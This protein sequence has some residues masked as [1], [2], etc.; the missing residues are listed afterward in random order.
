MPKMQEKMD[1]GQQLGKSR[2]GLHQVSIERL[3]TQAGKRLNFCVTLEKV[4]SDPILMIL[5]CDFFTHFGSC[6]LKLHDVLTSHLEAI[7]T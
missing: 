2:A 5:K 4:L 7:V 1:V 3:P 6:F